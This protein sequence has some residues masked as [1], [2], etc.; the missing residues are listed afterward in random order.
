MLN[1]KSNYYE[2]DNSLTSP[3]YKWTKETLKV[4]NPTLKIMNDQQVD[5]N[6]ETSK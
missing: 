3:S 5:D 1:V 2:A 6:I 4:F